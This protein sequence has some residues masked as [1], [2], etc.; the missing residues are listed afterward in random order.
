MPQDIKAI[1]FDMD[2]TLLDYMK[3]KR[4]ATRAAVDAMIK[5]GLKMSKTKAVKMMFDVYFEKGFEYRQAFQEFLKRTDSTGKVNYRILA[6]AIVAY[7][8]ARTHVLTP[9]SGALKVLRSLRKKGYILMLVTD[10]PRMKGWIRLAMTGLHREFEHVITFDDTGKKKP[11][12]IPFKHALE[13]LKLKPSQV[14]VVGDSWSRD[15]APAKKLGM[16]TCIA[17]YGRDRPPKGKPDH[18]LNSVKD[19]LTICK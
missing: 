6:P 7:R 18:K 19:I 3:F 8:D 16:R 5:E 2:N 9:Y 10:A 12:G 13:V 17:M 14:M 4:S 11:T 1:I 15:M